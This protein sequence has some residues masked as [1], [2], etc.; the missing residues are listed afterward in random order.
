MPGHEETDEND[1]N[2]EDRNQ[3]HAEHRIAFL[4]SLQAIIAF[5]TKRER[6]CD[7]D[8]IKQGDLRLLDHVRYFRSL[9][10]L[11]P[12]VYFEVDTLAGKVHL[13]G[14]GN[15]FEDAFDKC[16]RQVREMNIIVQ[17]LHLNLEEKW[18][19]AII[20]NVHCQQYFEEHMASN[21]IMAEVCVLFI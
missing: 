15:S 11:H 4:P 7:V 3:A 19:W 12:G 9:K 13:R 5:V 1:G 18:K 8:E 6:H 16:F 20:A 21:D 10:S 14:R 2:R 17:N